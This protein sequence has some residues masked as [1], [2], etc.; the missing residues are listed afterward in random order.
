M[1]APVKKRNQLK[2]WLGWRK[3]Y[4][5][6]ENVKIVKKTSS[7][8]VSGNSSA[9]TL[10]N[11]NNNSS[12]TILKK[13]VHQV[14]IIDTE[15]WFLETDFWQW[16]GSG[17]GSRNIHF[18]FEFIK[19]SRLRI[20]VFPLHLRSNIDESSLQ[21]VQNNLFWTDY[22]NYAFKLLE[23]H[24]VS[25]VSSK[26]GGKKITTS[27]WEQLIFV[28]KC[29]Q[30][31]SW[32][33]IENDESDFSRPLFILLTPCKMTIIIKRRIIA[34]VYLMFQA[35][36]F[37]KGKFQTPKNV[38]DSLLLLSNL[39]INLF[40]PFPLTWLLFLFPPFYNCKVSLLVKT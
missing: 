27:T 13:S 29:C 5:R 1:G 11:P 21:R 6:I 40:V 7:S 4:L 24:F 16:F 15:T 36:D 14:L 30:C 19:K 34:L 37:W 23:N 35:D 33:Q 38:L 8:F 9:N 25:F 10:F 18:C 2:A 31:V 20:K 22:L 32:F 17:C 12:S 39:K 28:P 26:Q 3:S